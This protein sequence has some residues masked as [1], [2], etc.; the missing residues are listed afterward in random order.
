MSKLVG[1]LPFQPEPIEKLKRRLPDAMIH[2]YD[3]TEGVPLED[4]PSRK[5]EHVFDFENG[6]R[7]IISRDLFFKEDGPQFHVS[8]SFFNTPLGNVEELFAII[9]KGVRDLGI[10]GQLEMLCVSSAGIPHWRIKAV[11]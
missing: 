10:V 8:A 2:I 4:P 9:S 5:R 1:R 7:L 11:N 3:A 6:L